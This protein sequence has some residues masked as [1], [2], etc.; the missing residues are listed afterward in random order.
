MVAVDY[1]LVLSVV[2]K[3]GSFAFANELFG[4]LST[5]VYAEFIDYYLSAFCAYA[6]TAPFELSIQP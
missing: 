5:V 1:F 4:W 2:K 6:N 3:F